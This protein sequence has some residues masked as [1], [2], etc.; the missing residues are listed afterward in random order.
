MQHLNPRCSANKSPRAREWTGQ[1]RREVVMSPARQYPARPACRLPG[2]PR[3][4]LYRSAGGR[5]GAGAPPREAPTSLAGAGPPYGSRRLTAMLRREG[6]AANAKR[7]RRVVA[8]PGLH[9]AAPVRRERAPGGNHDSPRWPDPAG[10][11]EVVGPDRVWVADI[12]YI[13][14]R[15]DFAH[16]AA[17]TGVFTR[18]VRGRPL[19]RGPGGGRTLTALE[20]APAAGRPEIRHSG[21]GVRYAADD[22]VRRRRGVGAQVGMAA[23]G[24]P[25]AG[26]FAERLMRAIKGEEVDASEYPDSAGA[27][28]QPGRFPGAVYN[29]RR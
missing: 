4:P 23:A 5:D 26:G 19:G 7:V 1:R 21:R 12:T 11:P 6:R 9:G 28:R 22:C 16:P 20:R 29:H 18:L 13:R 2:S 8:G 10:A 15:R 3:C 17:V 27:L 25:R 14:L 24:A